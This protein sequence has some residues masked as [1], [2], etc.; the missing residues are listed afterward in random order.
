LDDLVLLSQPAPGVALLT[1][2]RPESRNALDLT[3]RSALAARVVAADNAPDVRAIVL[4]GNEKAFAAGADLKAI[5]KATPTELADS[6]L[7]AVWDV[8]A[9]LRKPLIC[10]VRGFALGAGCELAMHGDILVV[11]ERALLGQPEI[12]VGIMPGSGGVQRLTR[13][14]GRT[15]AMRLLLT[16]E[17]ISGRTAFEWGLASDVVADDEVVE[18]AVAYASAVAALPQRAA[19]SIKEVAL[20]GLDMPLDAALKLERKAF[21]LLFDTPDQREGMAAFIEKRPAQFNQPPE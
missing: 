15:R 9:R 8:L 21:W 13:L 7:F 6:G 5:A 1:L 3:L 17:A 16:G 12:K 20:A 11:G 14:V 2:N 10:A 4:T 19:A 18:K